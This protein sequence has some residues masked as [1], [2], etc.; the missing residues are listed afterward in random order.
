[1]ITLTTDERTEDEGFIRRGKANARNITRA[2]MLLKS[3]EGWSIE[4]LA[5]C[6]AGW[7]TRCPQ[8]KNIPKPTGIPV[9]W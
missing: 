4:R 7:M 5:D 6:S 8:L 1:M 9:K 2:H 3:A